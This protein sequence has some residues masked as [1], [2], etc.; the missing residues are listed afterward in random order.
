MGCSRDRVRVYPPRRSR[1]AELPPWRTCSAGGTVAHMT[2]AALLIAAVGIALATSACDS[3]E[4][5]RA[6]G[7]KPAEAEPPAGR[8]STLTLANVN[9][10]P[11]VLQVFAERVE[12]LS[13]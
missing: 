9:S 13:S 7:E 11:E 1:I 5:D 10:E 6:G 3:S 12:D 2:R 4:S 8:A